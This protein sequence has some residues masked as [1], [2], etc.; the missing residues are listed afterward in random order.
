MIER[1][2]R[3]PSFSRRL[4]ILPYRFGETGLELLIGVI[5]GQVSLIDGFTKTRGSLIRDATMLSLRSTGIRGKLH[6]RYLRPP[7]GSAF[8]DMYIFLLDING[9][10]AEPVGYI[11]LHFQAA[12]DL[13]GEAYS[14]MF[15][16]LVRR[17]RG[18]KIQQF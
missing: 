4:A 5:E 16:E 9:S 13:F 2:D 8:E 15:G 3:S 10:A 17:L 6:K 7:P 11:W 18:V 14:P 1:H 12:A